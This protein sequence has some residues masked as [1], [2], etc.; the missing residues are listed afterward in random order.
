VQPS[1]IGSRPGDVA[2]R[3]GA[4]EEAVA[5]Y[6]SARRLTEDAQLPAAD[7]ARAAEVLLKLGNAQVQMVGYHSEE[8]LQL[9]HQSRDA[10][11]ALDQQD[12][13]AEAG[14]HA[15]VF[16]FGQCRHGDVLEIGRNI[17]QRRTD[18]LRPETLVHLWMAMGSAYC[19]MGD[20]QQSL[21]FS[22][23]AIELDDQV[24]CTHRA[25]WAGADPAIVARDLVEMASRPMGHLERSLAVSGQ[26]MAIALDRGHL[27]SIVWAS[28]S[29]VLALTSFGC[30][31]E[32]VACA[33]DALAICEKHGFSRIGNI[34]Q[35]RGPALFELGDE[36]R[37]LADIQRGV[38]LWRER[39]GSFFLARNLAKL[40]EYQL[41]AN[42]L[43]EA[44][45]NLDEA[46]Q[47][48]ET[49]DE[50][51]HLAEIIRLRGCLYRAEGNCDQARLCLGRAIVCSRKQRAHLFELNATRD[52]VQLGTEA[53]DATEALKQ[54]RAIVDRFPVTLDVPVLAECRALLR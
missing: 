43:V 11:L 50:K 7:R 15:S 9:F 40:A 46:E 27:F 35:H 14:I 4:S 25:P 5:H 39:S 34:L 44:R 20:F 21:P 52:L 23:K 30:W 38:A 2:E 16:L 6:R 33:D 28:V 32:A 24:N 51:M 36:E 10:A 31:A 54:L 48:A 17:L 3:R 53:G 18:Q 42:Q 12:E 1:P 45:A 13:A 37:G 26:C 29:R 47:L 49:T 41:R 19:H 8:V 22:E